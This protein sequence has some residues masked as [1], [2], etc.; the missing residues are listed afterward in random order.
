MPLIDSDPLRDML[1]GVRVDGISMEDT[2]PEELQDFL[3]ANDFS[4]KSF[5]STLKRVDEGASEDSTSASFIRSWYKAVPSLQYIAMNYGPGKYRLTI[6]WASYETDPET[7]TKLKKNRSHLIVFE[8][9]QSCEADHIDFLREKKLKLAQKAQER[10]RTV[11]M[12]KQ[13]GDSILGPDAPDAAAQQTPKE[14]LQELV[15][16]GKELGLIKEGGGGGGL[17]ASLA[18]VL[19]L[20][21][22]LA[23]SLME[24][25]E[26]ARVRA[27]MQHTSMM[28]MM[29]QMSDKSN[30]Q[31]IELMRATQN[32]NT[33]AGT[34]KELTDMVLGAVDLKEAI[35]GN[36]ES[37]FDKILGL[38]E[39]VLPQLMTVAAMSKQAQALDPRAALARGFVASDPTFQ[40][41]LRDPAQTIEMVKRL[42]EHFGYEQ[43]DMILSVANVERPP[44]CPRLPD[45][46]LPQNERP[47]SAS[48]GAME[49]S[50]QT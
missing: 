6:I 39:T 35:N 13:L 26:Q 47:S 24:K 3:Q 36:K 49:G 1:G 44:E 38:V 4:A 32:T 10:L 25:G 37:P 17:M 5:Q 20:L 41:V 27:E 18:P 29:L 43:A 45:Q 12:D 19:S 34:M 46:Q 42:D 50:Q 28:N 40:K 2:V 8:I 31:L 9:D 33:G 21:I 15:S 16:T 11:K 23:T 30:N 7:E 48:D 22:P 14:Y